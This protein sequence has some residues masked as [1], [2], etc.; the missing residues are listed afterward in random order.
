MTSVQLIYAECRRAVAPYVQRICIR[1]EAMQ[2]ADA[3]LWQYAMSL[4][5]DRAKH[6]EHDAAIAAVK[7]LNIQLIT[8]GEKPAYTGDITNRQDVGKFCCI[9]CDESAAA[10]YVD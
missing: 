10:K 5:F 7:R 8:A 9:L 2:K 3:E 1:R 6:Q 4:S